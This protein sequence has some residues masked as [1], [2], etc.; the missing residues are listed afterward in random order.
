MRSLKD[1]LPRE[2]TLVGG[3]LDEQT[4]FFACRKVIREEFGVRGSENITP[5]SY[6]EKKLYVSPAGSLW[7]SEIL[8]RKRLISERINALLGSEAVVDVRLKKS[9]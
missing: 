3:A 2:M 6:R 9:T 8:L 4:I 7:A 5:H 1:L